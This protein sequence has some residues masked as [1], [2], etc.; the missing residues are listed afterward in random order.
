[1]GVGT[2]FTELEGSETRLLDAEVRELLD[3]ARE[4]SVV[5]SYHDRSLDE[6]RMLDHYPDQLLVAQT[7]S[8]YML[9]IGSLVSTHHIPRVQ[10]GAT[11]ELLQRIRRERLLHVVDGVEVHTLRGQEPLDLAALA[12]R[13]LFVNDDLCGMHFAPPQLF[14]VLRDRFAIVGNKFVDS[15]CGQRMADIERFPG[16]IQTEVCKRNGASAVDRHKALRG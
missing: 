4:H 1:M 9:P 15:L 2:R 8:G 3:R 7:L 5:A 6:V 10:S 11:E 14:C 13:R 12:S 16:L